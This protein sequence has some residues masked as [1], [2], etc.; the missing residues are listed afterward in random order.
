[1][2]VRN[3]AC[4]LVIFLSVGTP[5]LAED[6]PSVRLTDSFATDTLK[7]Y[8]VMG[9]VTWQKGQ[10]QLGPGAKLT[11]QVALGLAAEVRAVIRAPA[12]KEEHGVSLGIQGARGIA[13][14]ALHTSRDKTVL[15]NMAQ[16]EEVVPVGRPD[17]EKQPADQVWTVRFEVRYGVARAKAWPRGSAEPREWMTTRYSRSPNWEP[18]AV[19]VMA[20]ETSPGVLE[21]L[22]ITGTPPTPPLARELKE[23]ADRAAALNGEAFKLYQQG[24]PR[25]ALTKAGD[26]LALRKEVYG[27]AHFVTANSLN[28]MGFLLEQMRE[29]EAALTY[30]E[31]ALAI[32]QKVL[33]GDHPET[34]ASLNNVGVL[35]KALGRY[36]AA[37][38]YQEQ[39]L[40]IRQKVEGLEHP[41]TAGSWDNLAQLLQAM[42]DNTAARRAYEHALAIRRKVRG[43]EHTE[44][45]S[46]L[47]NLANL[48]SEM[49]EYAAARNYFE[50]AL[51]IRLKV[52]GPEHPHTVLVLQNLCDELIR[53]GQF[54]AAQ[55][56]LEQVLLIR[57]KVLGPEH[58]DTA[59]S[60]RKLAGLLENR[61]DFAAAQRY[62]EQ[63]L[64]IRQKKQGAEH[65]QT[66]ISL[67]NLGVLSAAR[68]NDPAARSYFN[69]A[70]AIQKKVLAAEDIRTAVTL[71]NLAALH[72]S[73]GEFTLARPLYEQALA[74]HTKELGPN[75]YRT[76][77]VQG[78]LAALLAAAGK[79]RE[80][81]P[82]LAEANGILAH[83]VSQLL[84]SSS[85]REHA[86]IV[87]QWQALFW[88]LLSLAED[89]P[90]L[91]DE[92]GSVLLTTAL[93]WKAT[94]GRALL[95]RQEAAVVGKDAKTIQLYQD[96]KV[97][98]HLLV[99]AMMKG[100]GNEP[101]P[102]HRE[103]ID[104]LRQRQEQLE[105][106]L[107]DGV[108][109]YAAISQAQHVRPEQLAEK[110][111]PGTVLIEL[112]KYHR[113]EH[114]AED[115]RR[116]WG[117]A[118]YAALLV[119]RAPGKEPRPA[120]R[121]I[122]LGEARGIDETVHAWRQAVQNGPV[123]PK[124]DRELCER[125][126]EPLA[127]AL[128]Q[129]AERLH[130]A[131]DGELALLPFEAIR[132]SDEGPFLVERF[133]ISYL[134]SGSDLLMPRPPGQAGTA[135]VLADP[136]YD[137]LP[138]QAAAAPRPATAADRRSGDIGKETRFGRLKGFTREAEA[139]TRVLKE[140]KWSVQLHQGREAS[141][142][143]LAVLP[144]PRLLYLITHGF[145]LADLERLPD[146]RGSRGAKVVSLDS[147]VPR[148]PDY[149]E[150]PLLRSGLALAGANRWQQRAEK[151]V[152]DGLLTAREVQNLDLWGTELVVLSACE[153]GL[154]QVQVGEGVLGL[155]R[156]FQA[157]GAQ[158]VLSSL[159]P[160]PDRETEQLMTQ[161]IQSWLNGKGISKAEA[162]R[163]AQLQLIADF[164]KSKEAKLRGAPPFFWAGF[165]CHGR[166][167]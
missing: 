139:V 160:V 150:D 47:N 5:L 107:A 161:L 80:A 68:G 94:S 134:S 130:I 11:R 43:P 3:S 95:I 132:L 128:P 54:A 45:A 79:P 152:S 142:E 109:E 93:S 49:E 33:G 162:L 72:S 108:K 50:Q 29:Y 99:Q 87:G 22:E 77:V 81:W 37:R 85:E 38:P 52:L 6:P 100:S 146:P 44:T 19:I 98:R 147:S 157:A 166:P 12:G 123:P 8:L 90:G 155:R 102:K 35:L 92:G 59:D 15:V 78:N 82:I 131:S 127:R 88:G 126:W 135:V 117:R 64:A 17:K 16:S 84:A 69:Q 120:I 4:Y 159:W 119:W 113:Y 158:T 39:A 58:L 129:G 105:R 57:Q 83:S 145:F 2:S 27:P 144:R 151:G 124:L 42:G 101:I 91:P 23:K 73:Q 36:T 122:P 140:V 143:A 53:M 18:W 65:P 104:Q 30:I 20:G 28:G 76:G 115:D 7:D 1:M 165:I 163:K 24:K 40:A 32:N 74:I 89:I 62:N 114:R 137:H 112:C 110:L 46:T 103:T 21:A 71:Q 63:D 51:A 67:N 60:L 9:E 138:D 118:R 153:T 116:P 26:A 106:E 133:T 75:H 25:D 86:G 34:A 156:A 96:L 61:K 10:V 31:Q 111:P 66:A 149:R 41:I 13:Q 167:D 148:Q 136:D 55:K 70:L 14:I 97:A 56:H 164:R 121:F 154:G 125:I 141:E 48:L